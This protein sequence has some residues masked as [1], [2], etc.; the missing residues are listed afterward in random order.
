[1]KT[2]VFALIVP[3]LL[4]SQSSS[5]QFRKSYIGLTSSFGGGFN[6]FDTGLRTETNEVIEVSSG[7]GTSIGITG[8][9][10]FSGNWLAGGELNY[11]FTMMSPPVDNADGSFKH[12]N[13]MASIQRLFPVGKRDNAFLISAGPV[14]SVSNTFDFDASQIPGGA[15]NSYHYK[16]AG[17]GQISTEFILQKG[18]GGFA[19]VFGLRTNFIQY[20][21]D[22]V[23]SNGT[24]FDA[25]NTTLD[26]LPS[27]VTKPNG[28]GMDLTIRGIYRF[29]EKHQATGNNRPRYKR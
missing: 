12:M 25:G 5:A 9:Y 18:D 29:A 22:R 8:A 4:L 3:L 17:G 7:G 6:S 10:A 20:K 1:M 13:I 21:L 27:D 11:Q 23:N 28:T 19:F 16:P 26:F 24:E 2:T 15:H 14:F